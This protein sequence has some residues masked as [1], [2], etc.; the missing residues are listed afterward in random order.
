[1]NTDRFIAW[2][3]R[4]KDKARLRG[5]EFFMGLPSAWYENPHWGCLKGHVITHYLKSEVHG[6]LCLAC[7]GR[8][9]IIPKITEE[10]FQEIL[11]PLPEEFHRNEGH[12]RRFEDKAERCS[13]NAGRAKTQRRADHWCDR[14]DYWL[15]RAA[16]LEATT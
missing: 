10:E 3:Q 11:D 4:E 1:M 15:Q 9:F 14:E 7:R 13:R 12:F 8:V 16:D 2:R 5:E 6:A